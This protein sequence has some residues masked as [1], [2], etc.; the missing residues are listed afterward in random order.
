[1]GKLFFVQSLTSVNKEIPPQNE[2][3][4]ISIGEKQQHQNEI[5]EIP[6]VPTTAA[7]TAAEPKIQVTMRLHPRSCRRALDKANIMNES[8]VHPAYI[9]R[10]LSDWAAWWKRATESTCSDQDNLI[11]WV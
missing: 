10:Y 4:T 7:Q 3:E 8:A 6:D 2:Y 5:S 9:Q 1:M 11:H